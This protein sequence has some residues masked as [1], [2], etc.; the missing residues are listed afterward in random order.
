MSIDRETGKVLWQKVAR[1]E[2]PHEGVRE[3]DGSFAANSGVT[4]GQ[5]VFAYFGSRGLYCYDLAGNLKWSQD[6]GKMRVKNS[7]GE[8]SSPALYKDTLVIAWDNEDGSFII[9]L[10]KNTGKQ[11]WKETRD[12]G[13]SWATP[14][15]VEHDGK[16]QIVT[17]ASR[18]IRCYDLATG[19]LLWECGGLTANVIPSPVADSDTVYCMSG[20]QGNSLLAIKLGHSGDLA[21]T[22]AIAWTH[23]KSTPYVPSPLLYQDKLYF[24]ANNNAVLSC[25]DA[26]SGKPVFDAE[27]IEGLNGVYAAPVGASGRVYLAGRN[28]ATVVLKAG[29]KL[30][31]LANNKLNDKFD[32]SPVAIGKDLFLRGRE[33][34]YCIAEKK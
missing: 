5:H 9:A 18:K 22:D 4:D 17:D 21:G 20:F 8:G 11:I 29:D 10:D 32:A 24:C 27:R 33:N 30:E 7:F 13:T 14:L 34:L 28:G 26:K 3:G 19:K 23:K 15:I 1:E 2:V 31:I 6:F 25:L 16:A 12:E